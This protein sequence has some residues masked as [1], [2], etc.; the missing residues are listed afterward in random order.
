[1]RHPSGMPSGRILV[2]NSANST[3]RQASR[4]TRSTRIPHGTPAEWTERRELVCNNGWC[5]PASPTRRRRQASGPG[6]AR[7]PPPASFG[8]PAPILSLCLTL[9]VFAANE[10]SR[11]RN[12]LLTRQPSEAPPRLP[13][14][15]FPQAGCVICNHSQ[16]Y[17]VET[18]FCPM[19]DEDNAHARLKAVRSSKTKCSSEGN[20][21]AQHTHT[22]ECL[23]DSRNDWIMHTGAGRRPRP[24][25]TRRCLLSR[26]V[27]V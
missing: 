3:L 25:S 18:R 14:L 6:C 7:P 15:P 20:R 27:L 11:V 4:A 21:R 1:M 2:S 9:C 13:A 23:P 8:S 24:W 17:T 16:H 19:A 12:R 22:V 10:R 5:E 26:G